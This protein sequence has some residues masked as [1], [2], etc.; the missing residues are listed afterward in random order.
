MREYRPD[1]WEVVEIDYG[2]DVIKKILGSWYGGYAGSD[3]WRLSSGIESVTEEG[4]YYH[5]LNSSG[6]TYI[7]HKRNRGMSGYTAGIYRTFEK[8]LEGR[9]SI[10]IVGETEEW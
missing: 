3:S 10:R 4:D 1:L 2:G 6:S 5:V 8:D 7:I 9:G